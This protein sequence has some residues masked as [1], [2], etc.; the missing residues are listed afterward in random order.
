MGE[1]HLEDLS[2]FERH[3]ASPDDEVDKV[4]PLLFELGKKYTEDSVLA[5]IEHHTEN[6]PE[7]VT[8]WLAGKRKPS[9]G[10]R[11]QIL[12]CLQEFDPAFMPVFKTTKSSKP[13]KPEGETV[14][15][16]STAVPVVSNETVK[17]RSSA[18]PEQTQPKAVKP[19]IETR[20]P[21]DPLRGFKP[22]DRAIYHFILDNNPIGTS[23]HVNSLHFP[24]HF[25]YVRT[26]KFIGLLCIA[27]LMRDDGDNHYT[28][29]QPR[30][31][32]ETKIQ[33]PPRPSSSSLPMNEEGRAREAETVKR[34]QEYL[35]QK[36]VIMP[37]EEA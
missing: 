33:E 3:E 27:G 7:L 20:K 23:V 15:P 5:Y 6:V 8:E 18:L 31:E 9:R 12:R 32:H 13:L 34:M 35:K 16:E 4:R 22:R 14:K 19:K 10:I 25:G 21:E 2:G 29:L 36:G 28:I 1:K 37:D 26:N 11:K 24:D 17:Q 30:L